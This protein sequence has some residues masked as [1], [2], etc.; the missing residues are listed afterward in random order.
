MA[1]LVGP[2]SARLLCSLAALRPGPPRALPWAPQGVRW[3]VV[4]AATGETVHSEAVERF[5]GW[6]RAAAGGGATGL[7]ACFL[8]TYTSK[9]GGTGWRMLVAASDAAAALLQQREAVWAREEALAGVVAS[10]ALDFPKYGGVEGGN[11]GLAP[12]QH[13]RKQILTLKVG[14]HHARQR[15]GSGGLGPQSRALFSNPATITD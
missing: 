7:D 1:L 12:M 8:A 4:D 9:D 2:N 10:Q 15:G 11:A 14:A 3:S 13:L 6:G 5:H